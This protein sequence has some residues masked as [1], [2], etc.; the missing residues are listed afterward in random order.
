M[1]RPLR[2][3]LF[4]SGSGASAT[5]RYRVRLAEEALRS[6]GVQTRAVHFTEPA[7]SVW[8]EDADVVAL[9][10]VPITSAVVALV[11]SA[12]RRGVPVTFD[13]DDR[14]FLQEHVTALPF[15]GQLSASDRELF[16][17]DVPRRGETARLADR[18][19]ATTS[20]IVADLATVVPGPVFLLPNGVGVVAARQSEAVLAGPRDGH[21]T[22]RLGYF[23]GSATHDADWAAI[24]ADVLELMRSDPRIE[25]WLVGRVTPTRAL[26]RLGERV[27]CRAPVGW[28]D[29][30]EIL[31][32]V[33]VNLAPLDYSQFTSAKSAI[34][35]LEAALV[36][37]P[38]VATLT[39]PFQ[40]AARDGLDTL[41][42]PPGQSWTPAIARLVDDE[43]LRSQLGRSA[44]IGA[45]QRFGPEVQ[46]DLYRDYFCAAA[47]H[48]PAPGAVQGRHS[49][50][51]ESSRVVTLGLSLEAYPFP[52]ALVAHEMAGPRW[53]GPLS[54]GRS[55]LRR[56]YGR[57]R[58]TVRRV[59]GGLRRRLGRTPG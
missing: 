13:I 20:A 21:A 11:R 46:A 16:L 2:R 4:V 41:L 6:R 53:A 19:S 29:L 58:R 52:A 42:V 51:V 3:V 48:D 8:A 39:E 31:A 40:Y 35:W 56:A 26:D 47:A 57:G 45:L 15:L 37:T 22:I 36:Q 14:V 55:G 23:S 24:E 49:V 12:R 5:L 30:F 28:L 27:Q 1:T 10:R 38:T 18:G 7:L 50:P 32:S 44:R 59:G 25:L 34:K 17:R 9:Y 33:D 43:A 54:Q